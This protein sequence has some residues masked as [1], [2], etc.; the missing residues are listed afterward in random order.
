M[1]N[2]SP[3]AAEVIGTDSH[4]IYLADYVPSRTD[5]DSIISEYTHDG[6]AVI[7]PEDFTPTHSVVFSRV[8]QPYG[9][10]FSHFLEVVVGDDD[11]IILIDWAPLKSAKK[12]GFRC[13][14]EK[15]QQALYAL[16]PMWE[17]MFA[18]VNSEEGAELFSK[19]TQQLDALSEEVR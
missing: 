11:E 1:F 7:V 2:N 19:A 17:S 8:Q 6:G 4:W 16:E 18:D 12:F 14:R 13:K 15:L 9:A 3:I 10:R 5:L